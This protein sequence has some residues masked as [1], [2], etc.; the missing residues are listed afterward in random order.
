LFEENFNTKYTKIVQSTQLKL[1][2]V[3]SFVDYLC[4]LCV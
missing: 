4:V 1:V 2:F 3:V